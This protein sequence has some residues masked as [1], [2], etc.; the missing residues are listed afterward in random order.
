MSTGYQI[1]EQDGLYYLTIQIVGWVD[2]FSRQDYRDIVIDN[3][4]YCQQHKGLVVYA[5]VI[6]SNHI[7]I[8]AQAEDNNLSAVL[9]DFKS[10]TSKCILNRITEGAESRREWLLYLF[11]QAA[12][13][14][15]R[16]SQY[17]VFTHENHAIH[18]YSD[19]FIDQK[20]EY[21]HDN[22]V[23]AGIV[24]E[25]EDYLYSSASNYALEQP[26]LLDVSIITTTWKTI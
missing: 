18:L 11:K 1:K 8:I 5:Y 14:H 19:K 6:M 4:K 3:L 7:H 9:R 10:Y 21:I 12:I 15:K 26:I 16:N 24:K 22:P 23:R 25:P 2:L 13:K 20:L 17:Q